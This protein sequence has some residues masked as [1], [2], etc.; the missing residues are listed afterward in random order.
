M[1]ILV[2]IIVIIAFLFI[3]YLINVVKDL[4]IEIKSLSMKCNSNNDTKNT[5]INS[6]Q[7]FDKKIKNDI[8]LL[9]EYVKNIFI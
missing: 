1:D 5:D 2:F 6:I 7:T 4:Q 9:L 8:V 3:Y